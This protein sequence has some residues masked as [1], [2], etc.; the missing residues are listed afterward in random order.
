MLFFKKI[1]VINDKN[2]KET[3]LFYSLFL[4]YV[5]CCFSRYIFDATLLGVINDK[6]KVSVISSEVNVLNFTRTIFIPFETH[7]NFDSFV[8]GDDDDERY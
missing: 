5:C 8:L 3:I 6:Y 7:L 4:L 1:D 2:A